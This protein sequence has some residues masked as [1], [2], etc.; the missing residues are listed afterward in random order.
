MEFVPNMNVKL[1]NGGRKGMKMSIN[2]FVQKYIKFCEHIRDTQDYDD[3]WMTDED[4]DECVL[5]NQ[6]QYL[7]PVILGSKW[8]GDFK[9]KFDME[10]Y[11]HEAL[12]I[13]SSG[14]PYLV[15]W[16]GG[17]WE[18]PMVVFYYFD[19]KGKL[20]NYIPT[21]G[22]TYNTITKTAF[23]SESDADK[24]NDLCRKYKCT[25]EDVDDLIVAGLRKGGISVSMN[26]VYNSE[27]ETDEEPY[28]FEQVL[29]NL[30]YN[31][32]TCEEDFAARVV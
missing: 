17:D 15:S 21:K 23:G 30:T 24:F 12:G 27:N 22:N 13:T 10:N 28:D 16:Y 31:I 3:W 7:I 4:A 9:V 20:R 14:I 8:V 5:Y 2:E 1:K 26:D 11:G 19:D 29:K 18:V 32:S 6:D 25:Y